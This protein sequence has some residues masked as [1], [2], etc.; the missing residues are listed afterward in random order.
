[1]NELPFASVI[2]PVRN[3]E[4]MI[5]DAISSL[6]AQDYPGD[7]HEILVVDNASTDGTAEVI[8]RH[9]VRYLHE[10]RRG[11]SNARNRGIAEARGEILAFID[12]DCVADRSWLRELVVPFADPEVGC[13]AGE[14]GHFAGDTVTERQSTRM[15]GS[16]QRYAIGSNPPYA[17]TAN[18]AYRADVLRRIGAFEPRMPRAQDV[19]LGLRFSERSGMRIAYAERA[20]VR[21]RHR[22]TQRGFFRQ[23]LGWSYGAGLVAAKYRALDGR[24]APPPRLRD[25]AI[26]ARGVGAVAALRVRRRPPLPFRRTYLEDAWFGLMRQTAWYL[27]A[28]AG[29]FRGHLLFRREARAAAAAV[30]GESRS[31]APRQ[32][33]EPPRG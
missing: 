27:G 10:P 26:A 22:T 6:L 3:G 31:T 2:V 28:R 14:L 32:Y 30:T 11:V 1:V 29:L 24:P 8:R 16:W 17:I 5:A 20:V 25:V 9:P 19:E 7:R 15:F 18:A 4:A 13:V 12:G 21:H 23:Q 33:P